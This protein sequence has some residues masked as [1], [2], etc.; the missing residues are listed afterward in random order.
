MRLCTVRTENGPIAAVIGENGRHA[1]VGSAIDA[2]RTISQGGEPELGAEL[3][4]D[5]ELGPPIVP[6]KIV[7]IG[8]NYS[9][10]TEESE[11]EQPTA[12]LVF[13]KFPSCV[14]G[15]SDPVKI[16][17]ELTEQVDWEVELAIV[18]GREMRNVKAEHALDYVFGYTV[19]NDISARDVQFGDGQ[20]TRGKSFDTF[21]PLG[22]HIVTADELGP[23]DDLRLIT[24]VNGET[25]QDGTTRHMVFGPAELL[26]FCSR[27][28][29]LEPGDIL[30][31]GTPSGCGAFMDPP[32][33]L[34]PGDVLETEIE[35]I[36][37]LVNPVVAATP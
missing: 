5:L 35:G 9:D 33:F 23:I 34:Q 21:C 10:H 27:S 18:I 12:P 7:A 6:G 30:L 20:W 22:P 4:R 11:V 28:F 16:D 37:T 1:L 17:R 24:R 14:T 31:T 13:A 2:I 15:P 26:A 25:M 32:R 36:G 8:L 29:P 19:A 3:A